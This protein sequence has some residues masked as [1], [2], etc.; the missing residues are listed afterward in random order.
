ML[1]PDLDNYKI[2]TTPISEIPQTATVAHIY[3]G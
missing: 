1:V 3:Y 2:H